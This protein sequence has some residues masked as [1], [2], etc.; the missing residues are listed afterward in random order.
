MIVA[1]ARERRAVEGEDRMVEQTEGR[2]DRLAALKALV[3]DSGEP[4][5]F[6]SQM[7]V[8]AEHV[9]DFK[10]ALVANTRIAAAQ[11]A[12]HFIYANQSLADPTVFLMFERWS[13]LR[14][15]EAQETLQPWFA[16][17]IA[18]TDPFHSAPRIVTAWRDLRYQDG[19]G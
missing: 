10:A 19:P 9:E 16:A 8:K 18:Q 17:Y 13:S 1:A 7:T 15:F 3:L 4:F 5:T 14:E 11:P 12:C 6:T 2:P